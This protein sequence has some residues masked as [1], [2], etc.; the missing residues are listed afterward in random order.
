MQG[1]V[2]DI[3]SFDFNPAKM[4]GDEDDYDEI[5]IDIEKKEGPEENNQKAICRKEIPIVNSTEEKVTIAVISDDSYDG[6]ICSNCE[7]LV[8][9][10]NIFG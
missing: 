6:N 5:E 3:Y 4:D 10:Y 7:N 9:D 2:N 1:F 8:F